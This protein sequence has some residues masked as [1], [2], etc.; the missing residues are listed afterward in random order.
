MWGINRISKSVN[1][2]G[3]MHRFDLG[4]K[5]PVTEFF[6]QELRFSGIMI[7]VTTARTAISLPN[8]ICVSFAA[9]E[10]DGD[11]VLDDLHSLY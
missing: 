11:D 5:L 7:A 8:A 6:S 9:N 2:V 3:F 1:R 4:K 10:Q